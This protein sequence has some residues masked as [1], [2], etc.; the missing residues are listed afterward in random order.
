M[1]QGWFPGDVRVVGGAPVRRQVS[2]EGEMFA[3][4]LALERRL[5]VVEILVF[6]GVGAYLEGLAAYL[7]SENEI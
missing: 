2:R 3:A 5:A 6:Y 7:A 4:H 1:L